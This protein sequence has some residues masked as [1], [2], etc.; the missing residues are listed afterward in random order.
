MSSTWSTSKEEIT[1]ALT[2]LEEAEILAKENEFTTLSQR[3]QNLKDF[4]TQATTIYNKIATLLSNAKSAMDSLNAIDSQTN[5]SGSKPNTTSNTGKGKLPTYHS[6]GIV[7]GQKKLPEK[8]IALTDANLKPNEVI[9]KLLRNEV[10][11]NQQQ[12]GNLFDNI[13]GSYASL[14]PSKSNSNNISVTIG[15]VHVHN[16]DNSDMIVNEIVKEL[17]LKVVQKLNSK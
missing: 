1:L 4:Q 15:D 12:I 3:I 7:D 6:G 17:P 16:P 13:S 5:S 14:A 9:A 2:N 8:L 10:V 11:L